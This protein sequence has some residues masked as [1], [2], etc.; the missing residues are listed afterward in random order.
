MHLSKW[1]KQ[2]TLLVSMLMMCTLSVF[3]YVEIVQQ[4]D[5][6]FVT[7]TAKVLDAST[8]EYIVSKNQVLNETSGASIVVVTV[9]LLNADITDYAYTIF[10]E[11][12]LGD[13]T[14]N[15]GILLLV[16]I[17]DQD[18]Y[19][20]LGRGLENKIQIDDL[21]TILDEELEPDFAQGNYQQGIRKV[22]DALYQHCVH[23]YNV[24]ENA[25]NS[26]ADTTPV[27]S[28]VSNIMTV[29]R[30]MMIVFVVVTILMILF[31]SSYRRRTVVRRPYRPLTPPPPPVYP[32]PPRYHRPVYTHRPSY[33]S[34]TRPL[35]RPSAHSSSRPSGMG[36]FSSRPSS[37]RSSFSPRSGGSTRGAGAGR[38][39]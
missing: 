22:F 15:N 23:L 8:E 3:G 17:G 13:E 21:Q 31:A 39:R 12:E 24:D 14:V 35:S 20:M 16:S 29:M 28:V 26:P 38:R 27:F 30:I 1:F 6:Y 7:D 4:D 19:C 10:N 33:P 2:L 18:Y 25:M 34:S 37:S 32:N 5:S 36:S 9:D 11:W